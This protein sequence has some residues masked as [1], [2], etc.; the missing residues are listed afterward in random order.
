MEILQ[1]NNGHNPARA[2]QIQTWEEV[3]LRLLTMIVDRLPAKGVDLNDE[4]E[5]RSLVAAL[6]NM[7]EEGEL[8]K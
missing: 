7:Y 3:L 1:S 4:I 2:D 8:Q 6:R 5:I